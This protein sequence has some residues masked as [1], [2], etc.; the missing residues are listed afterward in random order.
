MDPSALSR[1]RFAGMVCAAGALP[2]LTGCAW[3]PVERYEGTAPA[4]ETISVVA[5]GWHTEVGLRADAITGPLAAIERE[6][7]DASYLTFGWGERDYYMAPDP[8]V[9]DLLGAVVPGPAVMLARGLRRSPEETF[10]SAAV[11]IV[12]VSPEGMDHLSRYLW[13]YLDKDARG[14]LHRTGEGPY[15]GSA[16][17]AAAGTYDVGN[18]CN[19]WTAEALHVAGLPVSAAGVVFAGQVIDQVRH[20]AIPISRAQRVLGLRDATA[21][22]AGVRSEPA[23]TRRF[24]VLDLRQARVSSGSRFSPNE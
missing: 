20:L 3:T 4:T 9:M 15:P 14:E 13:A 10:G 23:A 16:F 24:G 21:S 17:Y 12:P 1:R 6:F 11:Y 5:F 18:T 2:I 22:R 7:P 8:G 19:T